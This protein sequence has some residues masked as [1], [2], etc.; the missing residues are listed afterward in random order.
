MKKILIA[1]VL[2]MVASP[3]EVNADN[4]GTM[5]HD[6]DY[7]GMIDSRDATAVLSEYARVSIGEQ[8]TFTATQRYIADT[9]NDGRITAVDASNILNEYAVR[10]AGGDTIIKTVIFG[11]ASDTKCEYQAFYLEDAQ[12][13]AEKNGDLH[14]FATFTEYNGKI[15]TKTKEYVKES[16]ND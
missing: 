10:S 7:N 12:K 13:Y 6:I 9:D 3:L 8:S 11:V 4:P 1:A 14:I 15:I 2:L 5:M 16:K